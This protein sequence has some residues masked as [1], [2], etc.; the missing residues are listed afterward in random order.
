[1]FQITKDEFFFE[2]LPSTTYV[3]AWLPPKKSA[4]RFDGFAGQGHKVFF[5]ALGRFLGGFPR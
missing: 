5:F 4:G 2:Q 1:M 3:A